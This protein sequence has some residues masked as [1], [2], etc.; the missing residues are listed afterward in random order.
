[1]VT[2]DGRVVLLDFGLV[3]NL[4]PNQQSIANG[5]VGTVEYMAPEQAAGRQ[6]G[7]AADWYGVGVMLYEALTGKMPHSGHALQILV[8]KQQV[9]PAPPS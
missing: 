9:E 1:M 6:V 8:Q 7:E 3:T 5:P 4:D 2:H